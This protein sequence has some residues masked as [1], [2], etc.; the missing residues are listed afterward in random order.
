MI[1]PDH[2]T[3]GPVDGG[4]CDHLTAGGV[5]GRGHQVRI[6][7][8]DCP[9]ADGAANAAAALALLPEVIGAEA[10]A[11]TAA[12]A[13]AR[14]ADPAPEPAC[15]P[16]PEEGVSRHEGSCFCGEVH[17]V[18]VRHCAS[19]FHCRLP[20]SL[21]F[22]DLL[23]PFHCLALDL[24]LTFHCLQVGNPRSVSYCQ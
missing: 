7:R 6:I 13:A 24:P 8:L 2:L 18:A 23:L 22:L 20:L 16:E 4:R 19:T 11:R 21:P 1:G 15:A 9:T 10:A 5:D 12:G 14:T 3:A 17:V